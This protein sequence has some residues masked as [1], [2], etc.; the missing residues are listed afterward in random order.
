VCP[1]EADAELA[2]GGALHFGNPGRMKHR[3]YT[4]RLKYVAMSPQ[5]G[6]RPIKRDGHGQKITRLPLYAIRLIQ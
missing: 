2:D 6:R 4:G 5:R 1:D 3:G